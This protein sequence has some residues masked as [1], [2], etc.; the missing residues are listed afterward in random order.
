LLVSCGDDGARNH[1][2][3]PTLSA[4][5]LMDASEAIEKFINAERT[6]EAVLVARKLIERAPACE[7]SRLQ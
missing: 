7:R 5:E 2:P 6:Q 4:R 1:T 3:A